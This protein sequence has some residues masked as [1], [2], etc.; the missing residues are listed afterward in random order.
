MTARDSDRAAAVNDEIA[1]L[2]RRLAA[3]ATA[4]AAL[5]AIR[6]GPTPREAVWRAGKCTLW[7]YVPAEG[8][9]A[10]RSVVPLLI[11]YSL[12]NR[13]YLLDLQ[14]DRSLIRGLLGAGHTVYLLDWGTPDRGDRHLALADY[15]CGYLAACIGHLIERSRQPSLHVLGICQ[16][17]TLALCHAALAPAQVRK[18]AT[19]AVPVDFHTADNLL[20]RL[21]R[22]VDVDRLV[23]T[24]GNVPGAF[25][26]TAFLA[27]R[28]LRLT[29]HKY[30]GVADLADDPAALQNFLRMEQWIFD[31][32]DQAGTAFAEFLRWFYRENRLVQGTL[33]LGGRAVDLRRIDCPLLNVY[34]RADHLV[35]PSASLAL[36]GRTSSRAYRSLAFDGGHVGLYVSARA[37]RELPAAVDAWLR[38]PL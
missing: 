22:D 7:R 33:E 21:V 18:L 31:S 9:A 38:E 6:V 35:P 3:A 34:A 17:G 12:V 10:D 14:E 25:L 28:P 2:Q 32:P 16:G 8:T 27:L 15:V 20:T 13:P 29:V 36:E 1:A 5:P 24:Y 37:Q 30:L 19:L 23:A 11:V 26:N 4:L